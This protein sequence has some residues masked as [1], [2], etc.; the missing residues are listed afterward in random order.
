MV[1]RGDFRGRLGGVLSVGSIVFHSDDDFS[2]GEL[3]QT[4]VTT[5]VTEIDGTPIV[6]RLA[7]PHRRALA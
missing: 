5:D 6:P 7:V 1:V 3:V 4:T 2:P